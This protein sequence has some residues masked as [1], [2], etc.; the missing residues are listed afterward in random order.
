[1]DKQG[2]FILL[3]QREAM[4]INLG[5]AGLIGISE[6]GANARIERQPA[7]RLP[8]RAKLPKLLL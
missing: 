8:Q 1:M 2:S 3:H 5:Q 7:Q 4:V 6:Q